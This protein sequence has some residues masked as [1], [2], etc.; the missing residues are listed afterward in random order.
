MMPDTG[1]E[2]TDGLMEMYI[3]ENGKRIN[4]MVKDTRGRQMVLNIA[5]NGRITC[6]MER[7]SNKK[8]E[9]YI[10]LKMNKTSSSAEVS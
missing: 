3:T 10:E 6:N 9:N 2:Y 8:T 4:S 7:E 1:M 5:E